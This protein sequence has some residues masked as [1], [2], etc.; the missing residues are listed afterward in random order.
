MHNLN[1]HT[2][3]QEI[4]SIVIKSKNEAEYKKLDKIIIIIKQILGK[5]LLFPKTKDKQIHHRF[6]MQRK[7]EPNLIKT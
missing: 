7:K 3:S 2:I 6:F 1:Q 5:I 4:G